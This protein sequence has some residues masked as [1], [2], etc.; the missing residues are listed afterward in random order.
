MTKDKLVSILLPTFNGSKYIKSSIESIL[1]QSYR[2]WELIIIDDGSTDK[3]EALVSV[4]LNPNS[5]IRYIKNDKNLGIQRSLNKGLSL[6][7]GEYI[8]RIDDD[9]EWV[10]TDK[11]KN[12]VEFLEKNKEYVLVGTGVIVVDED[13]KE[14][15]R[16]LVPSSDKKIRNKILGKNCFVHSSVVF[17]KNKALE[18]NGYSEEQEVKHLEDYDLWLKLGTIGKFTNLPIFGVK[19]TLRDQSLSS[20][21]KIEIFKKIIILIKKFK[22]LYPHYYWSLVRSWV[23]LIVYGFVLKLPIKISLNKIIKFYKES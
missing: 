18:F 11:L 8:A 7:I 3:T 17:R 20:V 1:N 23:R 15:F 19:L 5:N 4:Y 12:Q 21:N 22:H 10:D 2:N 13:K 9:D 14:I 16:Y 6:A